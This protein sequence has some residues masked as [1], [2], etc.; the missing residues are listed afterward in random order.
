MNNTQGISLVNTQ[1][2]KYLASGRSNRRMTLGERL[3][4]ARKH[5]GMTQDQLGELAE[6]GQAV[7]S[8]IERG[9]QEA[10]A[11]VVKLARVCG[12]SADWMYDE[13]GPMLPGK[14]V[15]Q[16]PKPLQTILHAAENLDAQEQYRA[17]RLIGT[18]AEPPTEDNSQ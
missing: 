4:K 9:D 7:I 5:A 10:S 6:C 18:L 1:A 15:E 14:R 16:L 11:Y 12:V 2:F 13:T 8:K 17:A 3:R